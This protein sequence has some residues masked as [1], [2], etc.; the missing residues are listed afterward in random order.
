MTPLGK[1]GR[2][3][4]G[5]GFSPRPV[6]AREGLRIRTQV[7]PL[8]SRVTL[9][10]ILFPAAAPMPRDL[11]RRESRAAGREAPRVHQAGFHAG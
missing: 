11:P 6:W 1:E 7:S 8:E 3:D 9:E 2:G 5:G 10:S 4:R